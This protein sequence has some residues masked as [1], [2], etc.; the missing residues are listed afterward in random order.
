MFIF[1]EKLILFYFPKMKDFQGF[2]I[3]RKNFSFSLKNSLNFFELSDEF[4]QFSQLPKLDVVLVLKN[5][6][7]EITKILLNSLNF[8]IFKN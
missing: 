3:N 5:S 4:Y 6:N 7:I 8:P 1:L 2:K